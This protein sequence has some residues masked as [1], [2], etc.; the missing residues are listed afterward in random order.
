MPINAKPA[1]WIVVFDGQSLNLVP[2]ALTTYCYKV[3]S[4]RGVPWR[5]TAKSGIPW[6]G[7][8]TPWSD[9][10]DDAATRTH[11]LA[12]AATQSVLVMCGGQSDLWADDTAATLYADGVTY[13]NAARAAGF[14]WII[15]TTITANSV[16]T[17]GQNTERQAHN[18]LL[19][20]DAS[21]AFDDVVDLAANANLEDYN[22]YTS[23]GVHWTGAATTIVASLLDPYLDAV[24]V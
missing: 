4:G 14:D 9:L 5:I 1:P 22:T 11:P 21:N 7:N 12:K 16:N 20:A 15:G 19:L 10:S 23:D 17:A 2:G 3:M 6:I 18:V 13:A 8:P 24:L